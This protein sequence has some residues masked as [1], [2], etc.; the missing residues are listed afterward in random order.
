MARR[1]PDYF[2]EELKRALKPSV[3]VGKYRQ[4]RREGR[5]YVDK[6]NPSFHV[7]DQKNFIKDF[8]AGGGK[9][10]DIIEFVM[11]ETGC[12][13]SQA[14]EE[15]AHMAGLSLPKESSARSP[16]PV[17]NESGPPPDEGGDP[18][19]AITTQTQ[20]S[21]QPEEGG[22]LTDRQRI[23]KTYPY[24]DADGGTIFEVCRLEWLK[25]GK[26]MKSF[27]QR[28]PAPGRP[29]RWLW[30]LE[31]GTYI[32]PRWSPDTFSLANEDRK[33]WDVA[34]RIEIEDAAP[35][36]LYRLDELSVELAQ[37]IEDRRTIWVP[38]GE[39]DTDTLAEWGLCGTCVPGGAKNFEPW[40]ADML[41][42]CD[43]VIPMDNDAAGRKAAHG[44]AA[45]LRGKAARIRVIDFRLHWLACPEKG[46]VTDWRD[47]A[48]GNAAKLLAILDKTPD[49][50][51]EP[52]ESVFSAIRFV[53]VD[54]PGRELEWL[55]KGVLT[56]GEVSIWWGPPGCGKSFLIID[57]GFAIARGGTWF[58]QRVKQ[59]LVVYQAGEGGLGIKRRIRAYR[60]RHHVDALDNLPFVLLPKPVNLYVDDADTKKIVEEI[61]QWAA[62]YDSPLELVVID[63]FSAASTGANENASEDVGRVQ[64]RCR[65]IAGETGAHVALV[66]HT[67]KAGGSPRGWGGFTGNVDNSIEVMLTEQMNS[68][69]RS[70][71]TTLRRPIHQFWIRKQKDEKQNEHWN[72]VLP[73]VRLGTDADGDPI[74]SCV[75]E[76]VVDRITGPRAVVPP[77]YLVPKG[78]NTVPVLNALIS[79][80]IRLGRQPPKE[81]GAP[82]WT[83]AVTVTEWRGALMKQLDAGEQPGTKEYKTLK[84]RVDKAIERTYGAARWDDPKG[85]NN[86][87]VKSGEWIWRTSRM[88][89]GVDEPP[90]PP[91]PAEKPAGP[92]LGDADMIPFGNR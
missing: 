40:Q 4:L 19:Y 91:L 80:I 16:A 47:H 84:E 33:N 62:Y 53:D 41:A 58:G 64:Q 79:A 82:D 71:G 55:I 36:V 10:C 27:R 37:P 3:V 65:Y 56:R 57:A 52:P 25:D 45:A 90:A 76:E 78:P 8:G 72:F 1:F 34:E 24:V 66:H 68:H 87:I 39:K 75:V 70:D 17:K 88:V 21:P 85:A 74:T 67:P 15:L 83:R 81:I 63:T 38:E 35:R 9:A 11:Q 92:L 32:R 89:H 5:E 86:I 54:R 22:G 12:D 14:V 20:T 59:G 46:D 42:G 50:T 30:G 2:L 49:W 60:Q 31:A 13:F 61:K 7:N 28:R 48:G 77:G 44:K 29:G 51:P 18:G 26:R 69:V 23:V 6:A 43:V 73:Q